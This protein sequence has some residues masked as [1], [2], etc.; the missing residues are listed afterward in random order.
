[1][2]KR[3]PTVVHEAD[4]PVEG[5]E[6]GSR[7]SVVWRTLFSGDRTPTDRLTIGIAEIAPGAEAALSLHHHAPPEAYYVLS[8]EG[9]VMLDGEA[10]AVRPGSAVFIPGGTLHG[11]RAEG[12]QPLRLLY[13]FAADSFDEIEYHFAES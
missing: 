9:V 11:A 1:M 7:G 5:W 6:D 8:G 4:C 13:V 2:K 10:H 3:P 12:D